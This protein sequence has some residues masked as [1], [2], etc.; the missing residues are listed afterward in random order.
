MGIDSNLTPNYLTLGE[1]GIESLFSTEFQQRLDRNYGI[2][3]SQ[4]DIKI[5]T[6][7]MMKDF[8]AGKLDHLKTFVAQIQKSKSQLSRIKT[9]YQL[10]NRSK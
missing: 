8:E 4:S 2:K 6:I 7:E 1:I 10:K 5:I 3:M 9:S